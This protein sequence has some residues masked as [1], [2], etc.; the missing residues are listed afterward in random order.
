[1][2]SIYSLRPV[3]TILYKI[4]NGNVIDSFVQKKKNFDIL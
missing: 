3:Y 2:V 4:N 1:M